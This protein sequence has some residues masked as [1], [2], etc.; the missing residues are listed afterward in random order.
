M[1]DSDLRDRLDALESRLNSYASDLAHH[2][3]ECG[4][5]HQEIIRRHEEGGRDRTQFRIDLAEAV[6][7]MKDLNEKLV[8]RTESVAAEARATTDRIAVEARRDIEKVREF[9]M[10]VVI[11]CAA[12]IITT[13]LSVILR[14]A[15]VWK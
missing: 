6:R 15:G 8:T 7:E 1:T 10:R 14:M 9:A 5:R 13:L 3:G 11:G 12:T 4:V 2:L